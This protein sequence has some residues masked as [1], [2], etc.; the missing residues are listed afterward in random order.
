MFATSVAVG[1]FLVS[2]PSRLFTS[3]IP[4]LD[5]FDDWVDQRQQSIGAI[6]SSGFM[7]LIVAMIGMSM[8]SSRWSV[9]STMLILFTL[10]LFVSYL[11][12]HSQRLTGFDPQG[13]VIRDVH[14]RV[15]DVLMSRLPGF[16]LPPLWLRYARHPATISAWPS[17][18]CTIRLHGNPTEWA[19]QV[20]RIG[21]E[22][23][24][25]IIGHSTL[26]MQQ[27][28][29]D[30]N[31]NRVEAT[32]LVVPRTLFG[33]YTRWSMIEELMAEVGSQFV[34]VQCAAQAKGYGHGA[35]LN[36]QTLSAYLAGVHSHAAIM[37][38]GGRS[39]NSEDIPQLLQE[40]IPHLEMNGKS[41]MEPMQREQLAAIA[42]V[43][44]TELIIRPY[45]IT[46]LPFLRNVDQQARDAPSLAHFIDAWYEACPV[47]SLS[48]P[49]SPLVYITTPPSSPSN[50]SAAATN[51]DNNILSSSCIPSREA[52]AGARPFVAYVRTLLLGSTAGQQQQQQQ[53]H[54]Q[55]AMTSSSSL[56]SLL[57][58]KQQISNEPDPSGNEVV[59]DGD[60]H[61]YD[62][63]E[64][65]DAAASPVSS[66][67]S[68][69]I[70]DVPM[71]TTSTT[72]SSVSEAPNSV[73][74]EVSSSNNDTPEEA[75]HRDSLVIASSSP[76]T[77][78]SSPSSSS[79]QSQEELNMN[80]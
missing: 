27:P 35:R 8:V 31:N 50:N 70:H 48:S 63:V 29:I 68:S 24:H 20:F 9:V 18:G 14:C 12:R 58:S 5:R 60:D 40:W 21:H 37:V 23:I 54:H 55:Q 1:P 74:S 6:R 22:L 49:I 57:A 56:S 61:D 75:L 43:I 3:L 67:P 53:Q 41:E 32:A 10:W 73:P 25:C 59:H 66:S 17:T 2:R 38:N 11:R 69:I 42:S 15:F 77:P 46:A 30:G 44:L 28:I 7:T 16:A 4:Y 47:S 13:A 71:A 36:S 80:Q 64:H 72:L 76:S 79:Q 65:D 39:L 19:R 45:G 62:M 52:I 26:H 33:R 34:M 78:I 51:L